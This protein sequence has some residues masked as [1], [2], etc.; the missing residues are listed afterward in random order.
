MVG[1]LAT[2]R[3][4][5][6]HHLDVLPQ[7]V[8]GTR[9]GQ[10][11]LVDGRGQRVTEE[12]SSLVAE[13]RSPTGRKSS[14]KACFQRAVRMNE[15]RRAAQ[16]LLTRRKNAQLSTP[17]ASARAAL[18][19]ERFD[20]TPIQEVRGRGSTRFGRQEIG[21]DLGCTGR[22][23]RAYPRGIRERISLYMIHEEH[24][25]RKLVLRAENLVAPV[26]LAVERDQEVAKLG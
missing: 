6:L 26:A 8:V 18:R 11:R 7:R 22:Y 25:V 2:E 16:Y 20:E 3:L 15:Q 21:W 12:L 17:T 14:S 19:P 13:D 1:E 24:E 23:R 5:V 4:R 9:A 10:K